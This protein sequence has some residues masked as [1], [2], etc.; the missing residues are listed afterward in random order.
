MHFIDGFRPHSIFTV[1]M[2]KGRKMKKKHVEQF[3]SFITIYC[4]RAKSVSAKY[5]LLN[6]I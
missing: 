5:H 6:E 3:G 4:G 2:Q 1:E